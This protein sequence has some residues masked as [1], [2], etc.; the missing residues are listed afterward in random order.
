MQGS[1]FLRP[2]LLFHLIDLK[3]INSINIKLSI[4][5]VN[6]SLYFTHDHGSTGTY[7][8]NLLFSVTV[9]PCAVSVYNDLVSTISG[10]SVHYYV[11]IGYGIK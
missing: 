1:T 3:I 4:L 11:G 7:C 2:V 9:K 6:F 5:P 10:Y 8:M